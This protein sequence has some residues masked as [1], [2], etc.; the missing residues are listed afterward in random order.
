MHRRPRR[1]DRGGRPRTYRKVLRKKCLAMAKSKKRPAKKMRSLLRVMLC[2]VKRNMAFV[3]AYL[4]GGLVL[5]D[6]R[7]VWNL[8]AI[9]RLYA[10]QK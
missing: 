8:D 9:R 5:L 1:V 4:A 6:K 3:D 7:D 10:Q 2:A